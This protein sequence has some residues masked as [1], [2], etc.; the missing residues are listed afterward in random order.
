MKVCR[1]HLNSIHLSTSIHLN[2]EL[3]ER[4]PIGSLGKRWIDVDRRIGTE[5][6]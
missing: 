3:Q 2:R 4:N 5:G 6:P 1:C